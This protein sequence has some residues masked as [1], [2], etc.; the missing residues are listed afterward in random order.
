MNTQFVMPTAAGTPG[1]YRELKRLVVQAGLLE[2]QPFYYAFK[3]PATLAVFAVGVLTLIFASVAG[4]Q[5]VNAVFLAFAFTQVGFIGHD[6]GHHQIFRSASNNERLGIIFGNLLL[7]L[8]HSWWVDKHNRHHAHPNDPE[9][10]P[11]VEVPVLA[12]SEKQARSKRGLSRHVVKFQAYLFF[13]LLMLEAISLRVDSIRYL[14]EKKPAR[15]LP[16]FLLVVG[17]FLWYFGLVFY[18]LPF[19]LAVLFVIVHQAVFGLYLGSV[20]A[21]NHKGMPMTGAEARM[22]FLHEQVITSRNVRPHILTDFLYG[23]LN[24]QIEHHLFPRLARNKL[25]QAQAITKPYCDAHSISYHET[26]WLQSY[27]EIVQHFHQVGAV[28][29]ED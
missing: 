15:A 21:P 1:D 20:F 16:E 2:R 4:L 18:F 8:S 22:D 6:A 28:C 26:S 7:G 5:L 23:G 19:G 11:D 17:H 25:K 29:R 12:F 3:I 13:P 9:L 14:V 27:R 10:D 24:Y